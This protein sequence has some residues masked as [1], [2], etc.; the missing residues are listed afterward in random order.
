[1]RERAIQYIKNKTANTNPAEI[2]TKP[3]PKINIDE[4]LQK[5]QVYIMA[6]CGKAMATVAALFKEIGFHVRGSDAK[7]FPPMR[8]VVMSATDEYYDGYDPNHLKQDEMVVVGNAITCDNIEFR[9]VQEKQIPHISVAEAISDVFIRDRKSL[10][11]AG[12]HGKTTTTGLLAHVFEHAGKN[13]GYMIGGVIINNNKSFSAGVKQG[14][15]Y[16]DL[17]DYFVIEGDEYNSALFDRGPKFLHYKPYATIITSVEY[18]HAD[19][20]PDMNDYE[21]VFDLLIE[22]VPPNGL[23]IIDGDREGTKYL[24]DKLNKMRGGNYTPQTDSVENIDSTPKLITYGLESENDVRA[25]NLTVNHEKDV[26]EFD[27][28]M[29]GKKIAHIETSLF[30][31]YNISNIL[32]VSALALNEGIEVAKLIEA[33]GTFRGMKRRQEMVWQ[34]NWGNCQDIKIIDDY[35]HHPTAVTF[36]LAGIRERYPNRRIVAMFEMHSS[37]S[38]RQIFEKPYADAFSPY[39]DVV[40][41]QIPARPASK[42]PDEYVSGDRIKQHFIADGKKPENV[43]MFEGQPIDAMCEQFK[44]VVRSGDVV[45]VM[46]SGS[47]DGLVQKLVNRS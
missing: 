45:V 43:F 9:A 15:T 19:L 31:E 37:T 29:F 33:V 1:M 28:I 44:S 27:L 26:Q 7:C 30:G 3:R 38:C 23:V 47:F 10:V 14:S 36:T 46:S 5:K 40:M 13:P 22:E 41:F 16:P 39:A 11:V 8:D 32:A 34:G 12:T 25:E 35:A 17:S 2:R 6:A 21:T 18:D 24:R 20:Y 4:F 42:N